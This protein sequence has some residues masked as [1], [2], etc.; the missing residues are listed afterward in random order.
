M[1]PN[2]STITFKFYTP[3]KRKFKPFKIENPPPEPSYTDNDEV[4]SEWSGI[5]SENDSEWPPISPSS[6]TKSPIVPFW[7]KSSSLPFVNGDNEI[8]KHAKYRPKNTR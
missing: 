1:P 2:V 7:P 8:A 6:S 5:H 3:T 4:H